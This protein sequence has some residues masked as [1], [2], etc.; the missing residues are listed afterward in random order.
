M[1]PAAVDTAMIEYLFE[2][3]A[4]EVV[5]GK[6][7]KPTQLSTAR[8]IIVLD[9]KRSNAINIGMTKLPPPR[10]IKSAVMKMD[11]AIMNRLVNVHKIRIHL[12]L[13]GFSIQMAFFW[14]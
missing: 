12:K 7:N 6:D 10:V 3:R 11:S 9:H 8:E 1:D 4:K 2:N 5:S 13:N 14:P